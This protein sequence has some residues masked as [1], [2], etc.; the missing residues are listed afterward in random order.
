MSNH[1]AIGQVTKYQGQNIDPY[2]A[3]RVEQAAIALARSYEEAEAGRAIAIDFQP[4]NGTRYMMVFTPLDEGTRKMVGNDWILSLPDYRV[5]YPIHI[6]SHATPHYV[7]EKWL[8]GLSDAV[9]V[10]HLLS[11]MNKVLIRAKAMA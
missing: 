4:G 7:Q 3:E 1:P 10:A 9:P 11:S 8:P 6:P 5:C 2:D